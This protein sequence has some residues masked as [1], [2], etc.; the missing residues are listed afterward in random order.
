MVVRN[1][2]G[3]AG[4]IGN[5]TTGGARRSPSQPEIN[6]DGN[7]GSAQRELPITSGS[8]LLTAGG[9]IS[10]DCRNPS[11][12]YVASK[13]ISL[14]QA[15]SSSF[16]PPPSSRVPRYNLKTIPPKR[17]NSLSRHL[18]PG[19][20][21]VPG[22]YRSEVVSSPI[23]SIDA[24]TPVH[25]V[26]PA[27][28]DQLSTEDCSYFELHPAVPSS[29]V[30]SLK[31]VTAH[32][33]SKAASPMQQIYPTHLPVDQVL[34]AS[35]AEP[36]LSFGINHE[37]PHGGS[38]A[39]SLFGPES[40]H[41]AEELKK[42]AQRDAA[43]ECADEK[44][45]GIPVLHIGENMLSFNGP[46]ISELLSQLPPLAQDSVDSQQLTGKPSIRPV[47][48]MPAS[49][50]KD[51]EQR[52]QSIAGNSPDAKHSNSSTKTT[53][54]VG[55]SGE[56]HSD[57]NLVPN[58]IHQHRST[59]MLSNV[60]HKLSSI[61]KSLSSMSGISLRSGSAVPSSRSSRK[62]EKLDLINGWP[63][64]HWMRQVL[65]KGSGSATPVGPCNLTARPNHPQRHYVEASK[66]QQAASKNIGQ[67]PTTST[68]EA[69]VALQQQKNAESFAR[70]IGDLEYLLREALI[71][72]HQAASENHSDD[73][74]ALDKDPE[75]TSR[76]TTESSDGSSTISRGQDEEDNRTTLPQRLPLK[77]STFHNGTACG[78]RIDEKTDLPE[79][80]RPQILK[81]VSETQVQNLHGMAKQSESITDDPMPPKRS[82]TFSN[83]I[84]SYDW[85]F[86]PVQRGIREV[87]PPSYPQRPIA[88]CV[89]M[90]E[91]R[92]HSIRARKQSSVSEGTVHRHVVAR[93][94]PPIQPRISSLGLRSQA[95]QNVEAHPWDMKEI[96]SSNED[97]EDD[98]YVAAFDA[99]GLR[100]YAGHEN[101]AAKQSGGAPGRMPP[102]HD[103]IMPL[104]N[105]SNHTE[106]N[107]HQDQ[108]M[109]GD[110]VS[111]TNR[112]HFS[113]RE[114]RGFS[115]SRSHRRA[116]I[117][118][119]WSTS[120]KRYVATVACISTALMGIIIGIYAGEVPA[121]QYAM[122]DEHHYTILGNVVFFIGLAITTALFWPLPLLH[123]RKPYTL[124]ALAILLPLQ[125]PQALA[126]GTQRS[127]NLA[128]YR[129]GLLLPR[130]ISGLI[131]GFAN[132][133]FKATL[134]DLFGASLQSV[135]PHQEFVNANDVRRH[136]G[137]M[138][139]WL[140]I[141]TWCYIGSLGIGFLIGAVIISGLSVSWGFW[142]TIILIAAVL[143]LNVLVPEVRRSPYR[144]SMAEVRTGTDV[145][146]RVARGEVKMHLRSTGPI[147][148]W[149]E[150]WAGHVLCI[151]MLKQPGFVVLSLYLGWIYG[152]VVMVIVVCRS[153]VH[154]RPSLTLLQLLGALLSKYYSFRP[155]YVGLGVSAIPIGA[156]LAIPFQKASLFSRSRKNAPR[157]DSMTFEKQVSW[158]SHLVRRAIFMIVLPFA[159]LAYTLASGGP[160]VNYMVPI[161]FAG[162]IGFLS[163]L[164]I[165]E[166]LG[167]IMETYDTSDLQPG[168]TGRPRNVLPEEVRKKRTNFS[169]FPRV[170]AAF[171]I[172]Q[173]FA[174]LIAAAAT[175][176]GGAIERRLGDQMAT[177]VVAGTLLLLTLLLITVLTRFKVVQIIPTKRYGTA[178]LSGPEDEWKPVIIGH[179]SGTTRRISILELG[180]LSRWSE[181]RRRNKLLNQ[182]VS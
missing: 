137:G 129:V 54:R 180:K 162:V 134:L 20:Q 175:G 71:I 147:W 48:S 44:A 66:R 87:G 33:T 91:Q 163:N 92:H 9:A 100:Q 30:E 178:V 81:D 16:K 24:T 158:T 56:K 144:R 181:I 25:G 123:G 34:E 31:H 35:L 90:Q 73:V 60:S 139:V 126:V 7:S 61:G 55:L 77:A 72:A 128:A 120:R 111:L 145:S 65:A 138:G 174:F 112:H 68:E 43:P 22:S 79:N 26:R 107:R 148:W 86:K 110:R 17:H 75:K 2:D 89:P 122:V 152:Q 160:Q 173:T 27:S 46:Q 159:G 49:N 23:S 130:A 6:G 118:R 1:F 140:G 125:F 52:S 168:M 146:R 3:P 83:P 104:P 114:P 154:A 143:V 12:H 98:P 115:L 29:A 167:I 157:T 67:L 119:D 13:R 109:S 166:C 121:I 127:S 117:A 4:Q 135:H 96:R 57:T 124:A 84:S 106:E 108:A 105:R 171:A 172:S 78:E 74:Y 103:T 53:E 41:E 95:R 182:G 19:P 176:T 32:A 10:R 47:S 102:H 116:P 70:V 88:S 97:S 149:E 170:T 113:I 156:L 36:V 142:I 165:A 99:P 15:N 153:S 133:N 177:A 62:E 37:K 179:P 38:P 155:Q 58:E 40:D 131:M 18:R 164:A 136:G 51:S 14:N 39:A 5:S 59:D 161:V 80:S 76:Y 93:Q 11:T 64:K 132:I 50:F 169:C 141:W 63:I 151:R 45:Q 8:N 42:A 82:P 69:S 101:G 85:A 28:E 21:H 150:V 94:A